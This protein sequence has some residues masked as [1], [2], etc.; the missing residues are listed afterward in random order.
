SYGDVIDTMDRV[1]RAGVERL[2]MVTAP[3][4]LPPPR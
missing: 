1:R 2:G 4:P 3:A